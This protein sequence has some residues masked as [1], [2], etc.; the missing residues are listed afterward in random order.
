MLE[1]RLQDSTDYNGLR[2]HKK[3]IV[4]AV[5]GMLLAFGF[6]YSMVYTMNSTV[7]DQ[8]P[9]SPKLDYKTK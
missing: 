8:I 3:Q 9:L 2:G 6:L 1:P 5:I 7:S 4:I